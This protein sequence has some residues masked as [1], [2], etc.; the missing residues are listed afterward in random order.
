[1]PPVSTGE[2]SAAKRQKVEEE[3]AESS[4]EE[5]KAKNERLSNLYMR[6]HGIWPTDDLHEYTIEHETWDITTTIETK[7]W[8]VVARSQEE[9]Y[10]IFTSVDPEHRLELV[11]EHEHISHGKH[12][13]EPE[14]GPGCFSEGDDVHWHT[15][16][17]DKLALLREDGLPLD[18]PVDETKNNKEDWWEDDDFGKKYYVCLV[19]GK[20]S[21]HK[22]KVRASC[23]AAKRY[24]LYSSFHNADSKNEVRDFALHRS[25]KGYW[26]KKEVDETELSEKERGKRILLDIIKLNPQGSGVEYVE[27][28]MDAYHNSCYMAD[29]DVVV[30]QQARTVPVRN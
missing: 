11:N 4:D 18:K 10:K 15:L 9:A 27:T 21:K 16:D 19:T 2:A 24:K 13:D 29:E 14:I 12:P 3:E 7:T 1:M 25:K 6:D 26:Q 8:K 30:A 20:T 5:E 17:A 23:E 28:Y 22:D